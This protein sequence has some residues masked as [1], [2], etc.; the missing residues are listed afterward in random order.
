MHPDKKVMDHLFEQILGE[1]GS[2]EL[3]S[4]LQSAESNWASLETEA[5]NTSQKSLRELDE[6]I[7]GQM[8]MLQGLQTEYERLSNRKLKQEFLRLQVENLL[9]DVDAIEADQSPA[10]A[11]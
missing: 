10:A 2:P 8:K 4:L 5:M 7:A 6:R 11:G 1:Q 3:E 9:R